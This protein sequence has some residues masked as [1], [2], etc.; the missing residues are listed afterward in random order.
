MRDTKS[1]LLRLIGTPLEAARLP[2]CAMRDA[3]SSL[4]CLIGTPRMT[5]SFLISAVGDTNSTFLYS[6][7]TPLEAASFRLRA[8]RDTNS[9]LNG[10]IGTPLEGASFR[11]DHC[12]RAVRPTNTSLRDMIGTSILTTNV[13]IFLSRGMIR[14]AA[15]TTTHLTSSRS[16]TDHIGGTSLGSTASPA[17][18]FYSQTL[19]IHHGEVGDA[20]S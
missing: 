7:V 16:P 18:Q 6:I 11:L 17:A 10:S 9:S 12:V 1:P 15:T 8:V 5:A 3:D 2:L 4:L 20:S 19:C 13:D 14:D